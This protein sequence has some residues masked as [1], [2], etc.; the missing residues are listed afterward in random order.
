MLVVQ[1]RVLLYTTR[2]QGERSVYC[3]EL[4]T[5]MSQGAYFSTMVTPS[6]EFRNP[7]VKVGLDDESRAFTNICA[8]FHSPFTD[9]ERFESTEIQLSDQTLNAGNLPLIPDGGFVSGVT[10]TSR[11][12]FI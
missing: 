9:E 11:Y 8:I 4:T 2:P 7:V 1:S 10:Y 12:A 6:H 3:V 5:G